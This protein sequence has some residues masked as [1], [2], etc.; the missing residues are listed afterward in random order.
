ML[1]PGPLLGAVLYPC[2]VGT[3]MSH[4]TQWSAAAEA[5][6]SPGQQGRSHHQGYCV[7][8]VALHCLEPTKGGGLRM[9]PGSSPWAGAQKATSSQRWTVRARTSGHSPST[10]SFPSCP[11]YCR[12]KAG[13]KAPIYVITPVRK[14]VF[15]VKV[16]DHLS[17]LQFSVLFT[18]LHFCTKIPTYRTPK[19]QGWCLPIAADRAPNRPM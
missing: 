13:T 14:A 16:C 6:A 17:C 2:L 7:L 10:G 11:A 8:N 12:A 3:P 1:S 4:S 19:F 15:S 9:R 5:G 18:E